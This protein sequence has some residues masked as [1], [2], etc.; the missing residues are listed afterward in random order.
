MDDMLAERSLS[1][2]VRSTGSG[3]PG[4]AS[5]LKCSR[6]AASLAPLPGLAPQPREPQ[7]RLQGGGR[8]RVP[9]SPPTSLASLSP[10]QQGLCFTDEDTGALRGPWAALGRGHLSRSRLRSGP[11]WHTHSRQWNEGPNLKQDTV[12]TWKCRRDGFQ[13]ST[14]RQDRVPG[15]EPHP[16]ALRSAWSPWEGPAPPAGPASLT[17]ALQ[18][19]V[20]QNETWTVTACISY[21]LLHNKLPRGRASPTIPM[22]RFLWVGPACSCLGPAAQRLSQAAIWAWPGAHSHPGQGWGRTCSRSASGTWG[23]SIGMRTLDPT[24]PA[25]FC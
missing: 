20:V 1:G 21:V 2:E 9:G 24:S 5:G 18:R 14:P 10:T 12:D 11:S 3:T 23:R 8:F 4:K 22:P 15:P 13:A 17:Q 19:P 16:P 7:H 6:Q 25:A